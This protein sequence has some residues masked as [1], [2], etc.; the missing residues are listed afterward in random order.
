MFAGVTGY[1]VIF[2]LATA[3][4]TLCAQAVTGSDNQYAAGIW[5]QRGLCILS[6]C[7]IPV[8]VLWLHT[9]DLLLLV[10]QEPQLAALSGVYMRYLL[11]GLLPILVF[12]C[13]KKFLQSQGIYNASTMILLVVC[14]INALLNYILVWRSPL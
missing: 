11:P 4:D 12:E 6:F 10:K 1:S 3:L 13:L 9:E 14:P 7:L 8:V 5:L 2:G